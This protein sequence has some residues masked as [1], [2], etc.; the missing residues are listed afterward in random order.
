MQSQIAMNGIR[1]ERDITETAVVSASMGI[2]PL[3]A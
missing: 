3:S 2:L 1:S